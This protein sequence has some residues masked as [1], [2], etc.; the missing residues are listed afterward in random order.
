MSS[1]KMLGFL[2]TTLT[3]VRAGIISG[4]RAIYTFAEE[5][6]FPAWFVLTT[7]VLALVF[8]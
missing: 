3:D 4:L 6:P 2:R 8:H 7:L 1:G 5:Y